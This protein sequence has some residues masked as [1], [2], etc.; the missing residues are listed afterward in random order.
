VVWQ[1]TGAQSGWVAGASNGE[2]TR[3]AQ[4]RA[5]R[6]QQGASNGEIEMQIG[7]YEWTG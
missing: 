3:T 6:D 7:Q 2:D 5:R 1:E 4:D